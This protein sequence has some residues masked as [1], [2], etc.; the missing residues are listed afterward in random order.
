MFRAIAPCIVN[1]KRKLYNVQREYSGQIQ[2]GK[3]MEIMI[4]NAK[5]EEWE[6]LAGIEAE[7][8]PPAEAASREEIQKRMAVFPEN[9]FV[10]EVNGRIAGFINGGT[11]DK[12]YLPDE[13]YHDIS[14]HKPEGAYQTVFGLNVLPDYRHKGIAGKLLD[15]MNEKSRARGKQGVILTCKKH[16]LGFYEKH[17]YVN[18]G[19]A[20]SAHGNAQW[21]DM[22]NIF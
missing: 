12:P 1:F 20:D 3:N 21:Y 18:Y 2:E 6:L 10:A 11:T 15:Y 14:L 5:P 8:F 9:F 16:L 4:R 13:M 19:P 17:G 7:C 22:R